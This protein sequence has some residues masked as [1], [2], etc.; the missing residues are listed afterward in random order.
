MKE[1]KTWAI[2][3]SIILLLYAFIARDSYTPLELFFGVLGGWVI[4][5]VIM[6]PIGMVL[7]RAAE[8]AT[9]DAARSMGILPVETDATLTTIVKRGRLVCADCGAPVVVY[10]GRSY[11]GKCHDYK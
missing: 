2:V 8:E 5:L 6:I 7:Q 4:A 10:G 11:C 3:A 1:Y 9:K